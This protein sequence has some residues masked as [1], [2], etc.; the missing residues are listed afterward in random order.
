M[1]C[2]S[3]SAVHFSKGGTELG[4]PEKLGKKIAF[5]CVQLWAKGESWVGV[6]I[7]MGKLE[8]GVGQS[9]ISW[10]LRTRGVHA[11]FFS[12][13]ARYLLFSHPKIPASDPPLLTPRLASLGTTS[14]EA[15]SLLHP[16]QLSPTR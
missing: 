10:G 6:G 2:D 13:T 11:C 14:G 8:V 12:S 1:I 7:N 9:R 16:Y 4:R 3:Q 15:E 5:T